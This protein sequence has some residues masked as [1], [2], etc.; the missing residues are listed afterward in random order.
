MD[1]ILIKDYSVWDT[2]RTHHYNKG[3]SVEA[4]N[5]ISAMR[6]P[7]TYPVIIVYSVTWPGGYGT[8]NYK[9]I[10]PKDFE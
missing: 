3:Y 6:V 10:Y 2:W 9:Y 1:S 7:L 8:W 4:Q 5:K